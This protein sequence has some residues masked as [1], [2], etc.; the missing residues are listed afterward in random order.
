MLF[1]SEHG[2]VLKIEGAGGALE[3]LPIPVEHGTNYT[4]LGLRIGAAAY[5]PDVSRLSDEAMA[6]LAGL[7]LLILDALRFKPHPTHFSVAEALAAIAVLKPKRAVLTNLHTDIDYLKLTN[8]L[9]DGIE[10]AF[11]GWSGSLPS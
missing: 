5:V 11:D 3:F 1:R 2:R 7:D 10:L 9:P 6:A 8:D 4:A